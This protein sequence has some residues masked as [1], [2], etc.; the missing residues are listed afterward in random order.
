M[1]SSPKVGDEE[2]FIKLA[3]KGSITQVI[4]GRRNR[5]GAVHLNSF[6]YISN[7]SNSAPN[8]SPATDLWRSSECNPEMEKLATCANAVQG[9]LT[10]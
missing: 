7:F 8:V 6:K 10:I 9:F 4:R 2:W 1:V 3:E 5:S